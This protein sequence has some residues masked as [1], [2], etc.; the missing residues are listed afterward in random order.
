MRNRAQFPD[1]RALIDELYARKGS[2]GGVGATPLYSVV[3]RP[4]DT[5]GADNVFT[6][7]PSLYAKCSTIQG[8]VR[9]HV[10]DS[11]GPTT[12]PPGAYN[13]DGWLL[14]N[15]AGAAT[16]T[17]EDGA[18]ATWANL[19]IE[20]LI[21]VYQGAT[22]F[23]NTT[24]QANL[25][26][27]GG[28]TLQSSGAGPFL[29]ASTA[30]G[31]GFVTTTQGGD[32]GDGAHVTFTSTAPAAL[33]VF[34]SGGTLATGAITGT[35]TSIDWDSSVDMPDLTSLTGVTLFYESAPQTLQENSRNNGAASAIDMLGSALGI[36]REKSG[37]VV[38]TCVFT[39]V[40]SAST[41]LTGQFTRRSAVSSWTR[42]PTT[43]CT[44]TTFT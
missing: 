10:D 36:R 8:G 41:T 27:F 5:S 21:V 1:N 35:G 2:G 9:V 28:A 24:G 29:E 11:F 20:G 19:W 14:V 34:M 31:F 30:A 26:V 16:L 15:G 18:H 7:W 25:Y 3:L 12:I 23:F 39:V 44:T 40:P 6:S 38:L 42:C 22:P 43:R 33:E 13:I 17:I 37:L 32:I 4:G